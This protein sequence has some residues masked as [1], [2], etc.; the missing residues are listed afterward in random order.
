MQTEL[1]NNRT[2]LSK[3][4]IPIPLLAFVFTLLYG[5]ALITL[6]FIIKLPFLY[7]VVFGVAFTFA[8]LYL[9]LPLN[10]SASLFFI[11][12][13]L[14]HY[15][16]SPVV[17]PVAGLVVH[18]REVMLLLFVGN[19]FVN[20]IFGRVYWRKSVFLYFILLY[21]LFFIYIATIGF[22]SGYD[23][24]RVVAE[25]RFP[26]FFI[27]ALI[28]PFAWESLASLRKTMD[29]LL[30]ITITIALATCA[31]FLYLFVT[32]KVLRVQNFLGE[33]IPS[34]VGPFRLQE[35]RFN[36]HMFFEIWFIVFLSLF[37]YYKDY[38]KKLLAL[39][40]VLFFI[41]PLFI[42][43][44][45]T[46]IVTVFFGSL[47]VVIL[48]LPSKLRPLAIIGFILC[49][50]VSLFTLIFLFHVG[51][52]S[53]TNSQLGISLQA[54]L[55]EIT[56]ALD[57]FMKSPIFGTGMGSQFE[58]LGLA[59][60]F[61]K[62]LYAMATYQTLHNL[63][64]YWLFKGG[65]VGFSI[66]AISLLGILAV[67]GYLV[68]IRYDG[69]DKGY[70]VGYWC[71]LVSQIIVMSLTFPRLSYPIGQVYLSFSIAVFIILE[72]EIKKK[73]N[74]STT[75]ENKALSPS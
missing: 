10:Y 60:N 71:A 67:S 69:A 11:F 64:V 74:I 52:L 32:G 2:L 47:L 17:F 30:I 25:T 16:I 38:K 48:Y 12:T 4:S 13:L 24:H 66:I 28:F 39:L 51:I 75:A 35:V 15:Y 54:R 65:I 26:V 22:L 37:F 7:V 59:S 23:W 6:F 14:N 36:G 18:P 61:W 21:L 56:G 46:A 68:N 55:V 29:I 72:D 9:L 27:S 20:L 49:V 19:F 8:G 62:D 73:M 70:W 44:M 58:G 41:I 1:L 53:W 57:N 43:M 5:F 33:F 3:K 63:W 50:V 34:I 40:M 42:L 45:K 31:L